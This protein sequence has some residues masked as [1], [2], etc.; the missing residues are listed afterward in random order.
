MGAR[1]ML[2]DPPPLAKNKSFLSW[3]LNLGSA[4][5]YRYQLTRLNVLEKILK[6]CNA[7]LLTLIQQECDERRILS[8][9]E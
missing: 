3:I 1:H 9:L 8:R 6:V 7:L 4:T 2:W 5:Q